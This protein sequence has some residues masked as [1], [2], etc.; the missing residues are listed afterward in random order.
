[1]SL[2]GI[3]MTF[4]HENVTAGNA[5]ASWAPRARRRRPDT[6]NDVIAL[7]LAL[8]IDMT[9]HVFLIASAAGRG[10]SG[11]P[12]HRLHHTA[13]TSDAQII[14]FGGTTRQH[15]SAERPPTRNS[16]PPGL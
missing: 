4:T 3:E 2:N 6:E 9:V 16:P 1:V 14:P 7:R 8:D 11:V 5:T 10:T 12:S 15:F 13:R